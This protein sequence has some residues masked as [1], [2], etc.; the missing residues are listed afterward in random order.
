MPDMPPPTT[1]RVFTVPVLGL[2]PGTVIALTSAQAMR[3]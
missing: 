3:T 1:S 2:P